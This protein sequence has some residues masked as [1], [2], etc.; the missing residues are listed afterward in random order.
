MNFHFE[1]D[2]NKATANATKHNVSF[3]EAATVFRDPVAAIFD[4]EAHSNEERREL[5]IGHS[6]RNHLLLVCF[7]EHDDAIRIISARQATRRERRDYEEYQIQ[8]R[9]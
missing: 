9:G 1:W 6:D 3:E 5:I 8:R 4:D 7:S 2:A